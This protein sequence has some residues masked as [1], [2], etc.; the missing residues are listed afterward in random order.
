MAI[1]YGGGKAGQHAKNKAWQ[2]FVRI[3]RYEMAAMVVAGAAVGFT[4]AV[5]LQWW[6]WPLQWVR[7]HTWLWIV[8]GI[9]GSAST[10]LILS[11]NGFLE[12][13]LDKFAKERIRWLRGGQGEALV[14]WHLRDDLSDAWHIFHNVKLWKDGDLDHVLIGPRGL[15]CISTKSNRGLYSAGRDGKYLLNEEE[16]DHLHEAQRLALQL[17]DRL[18]GILGRGNVP[19][20]QPVLIAPFAYIGFETFQERAWVLHEGNLPDAFENARGHELT[21]AE[22]ERCAKAV[23]S[24]V[25]NTDGI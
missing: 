7:M 2:Y 14:A 15:Y 19:W 16:T 21:A 12:K 3:Y 22:I 23:R 18:A 25:D 4:A 8:F 24:I 17:R 20:I 13:Y 1:T 5:L 9:A 10:I 11:K 6:F